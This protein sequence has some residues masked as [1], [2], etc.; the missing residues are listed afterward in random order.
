MTDAHPQANGQMSDA[1]SAR[2][3]NED[4]EDTAG[5]R[6]ATE[7][8]LPAV[9]YSGE[10]SAWPG[11]PGVVRPAGW[12]LS[13][14]GEAAPPVRH[15]ME[16]ARADAYRHP[17]AEP[18]PDGIPDFPPPAVPAAYAPEGYETAGYAP[19]G[20]TP[21][22]YA[23]DGYAPDGYEAGGYA[24]GDHDVGYRDGDHGRA[25]HDDAGYRDGDHGR[26][27]PT[28]PATA[29]V[30]TAR[31]ATT[32]RTTGTRI[33][34]RH[35]STRVRSRNR[36]SGDRRVWRRPAPGDPRAVRRPGRSRCSRCRLS[37]RPPRCAAGQEA[38]GSSFRRERCPGFTTRPTGP[39]GS[40]RTGS[41]GTR[42][43]AGHPRWLPRS[44][45]RAGA[46]S[47]MST[48]AAHSPRSP[49]RPATAAR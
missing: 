41:G 1:K 37:G 21:D 15:D 6:T 47:R 33:R 9:P 34:S 20:Y 25:D 8:E 17:A 24:P 28:T 45:R 12:F 10:A 39:A 2:R 11:W 40:C 29:T 32:T 36:G 43:S 42:V 14:A 49:G 35:R 38:P 18:Q 44:Q 13:A 23:P 4:L 31:A 26:A 46:S 3:V 5:H 7:G 27:D 22:D 30:T 16:P 48:R 19:D